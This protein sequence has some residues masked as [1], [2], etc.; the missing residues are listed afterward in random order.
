MYTA[1]DPEVINL[2]LRVINTSSD[3]IWFLL[4]SVLFDMHGVFGFFR[5]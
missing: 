3:Q 1:D 2:L 4:D 5:C